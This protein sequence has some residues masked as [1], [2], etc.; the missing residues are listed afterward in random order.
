MKK[1]ISLVLLCSMAM[2]AYAVEVGN[3]DAE[4][5]C[6][7]CNTCPTTTTTTCNSCNSCGCR[8]EL[9]QEE[10]AAG[11]A[12]CACNKPRPGGRA[13]V[14]EADAEKCCNKPCNTCPTTTTTCN[15]CNS[16]GCRTELT[17]EEEAAGVAR[18]ACN[19]PRPGGRAEVGNADAEKCCNSC[20]TCPTTT[21]TC[22]SCNS[23]GCKTVLTQEEEAAGVARCGCGKPRPNGRAEVGE[24]DAEKCCNSCNTCP[25][26]TTTTCNSCNSCGCKTVL[27]Q[28]EAAA[29][30]QRCAC[31]KPRPGGRTANKKALARV[32][33]ARKMQENK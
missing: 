28:E 19:K 13:E 10:E 27:T 11:V 3:A 29:G 21:T 15:S 6:N 7:S 2:G 20:N 9:T 17:Q 1:L 31:N 14:G 8:T 4:K 32:T 25:T 24:A 18:C 26:T 22:N 5:C 12:R 16:C 30:A 33:V 23:C